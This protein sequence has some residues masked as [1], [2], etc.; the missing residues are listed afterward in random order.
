MPISALKYLVLLSL[1]PLTAIHAQSPHNQDDW[2]LVREREGIK[3]YVRWV[4]VD[5]TKK[6]RQMRGEMT[7]NASTDDM[8][9]MLRDD[10]EGTKWVNRTVEFYH[11]DRENEATWHTF[12]ELG[13]PWPFSNR[14]LVTKNNLHACADRSAF[15]IDIHAVPDYVPQRQD[16]VRILHFE[17]NWTVESLPENRISVAY[18]IVTKS[19]SFLPRSITDPIIEKGFWTTLN[20]LRL[21]AEERGTNNTASTIHDAD[22]IKIATK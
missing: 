17:G 15:R 2:K 13:I 18:E 12:S 7:T 10:Q 4:D 11:F 21:L 16:A 14:D 20:K 6:V 22:K 1:A 3:I 19:D 5:G 8:L 9:Y